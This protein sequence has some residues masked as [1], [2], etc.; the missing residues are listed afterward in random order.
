M[1]NFLRRRKS[2]PPVCQAIYINGIMYRRD[3][4]SIVAFVADR[5]G[6]VPTNHVAPNGVPIKQIAYALALIEGAIAIGD[7]PSPRQEPS[8]RIGLN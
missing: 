3:G 2:N 1:F 4:E 5:R 6:I 7:T 8:F